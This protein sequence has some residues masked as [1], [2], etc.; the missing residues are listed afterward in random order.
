LTQQ[1]SP[2]S[3]TKR[4]TIFVMRGFQLR[5]VGLVT[6]SLLIMLAIAGAHT[7]YLWNSLSVE[8][9]SQYL[10]MIQSSMI[11]FFVVGFFYVVV[12]TIAAVFL[13]HRAVGPTRRIEEEIR[14]IADKKEGVHLLKVRDG[15]D[16]E[17]LIGA[18]NRILEKKR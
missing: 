7:F 6:G 3:K 13:S 4:T 12:V 9:A 18:I 15:D 11:R 8:N 2:L 5:Y 14:E 1:D 10:P 17:G 16:F